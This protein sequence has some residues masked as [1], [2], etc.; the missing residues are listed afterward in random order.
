MFISIAIRKTIHS[1]ASLVFVLDI[2]WSLIQI[3]TLQHLP[4][5]I[6]CS[7]GHLTGWFSKVHKASVKTSFIW[8]SIP[9][10]ISSSMAILKLSL[11]SISR[12]RVFHIICLAICSPLEVVLIGI[13]SL[14]YTTKSS[15][16]S[17]CNML[18][19]DG[20]LILSNLAMELIFTSLPLSRM[21]QIA[22]R[23]ISRLSERAVP[24]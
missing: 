21:C 24:I 3:Y 18:T 5:G 15:S 12:R 11:I 17:L 22:L 8:C 9:H 16:L 13:F 1:R 23:Y 2:H 4:G 14:L 7:W 6:G 20:C 19:T 10:T